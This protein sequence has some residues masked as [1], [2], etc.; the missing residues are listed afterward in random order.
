MSLHC[1]SWQAGT[2]D[3]VASS[4]VPPVDGAMISTRRGHRLHTRKGD[5]DKV[6]DEDAGENARQKDAHHESSSSD[7]KLPRPSVARRRRAFAAALEA[8]PP[9]DGAGHGLLKKKQYRVFL[10]LSRK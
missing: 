10:S 7:V 5:F 6:H 8:Y 3:T 9:D 4:M 2:F 1:A